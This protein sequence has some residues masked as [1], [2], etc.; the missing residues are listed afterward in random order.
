MDKDYEDLQ[1]DTAAGASFV[2]PDQKTNS[3]TP[4]SQTNNPAA[5]LIRQ[6]VASLYEKE[7][8]AGNEALDILELGPGLKKT[9]HQQFIEQLVGSGQPMVEIQTQWHNYYA[10]LPDAEKHAVWQE[11]YE[12]HAQV[13]GYARSAPMLAPETEATAASFGQTQTVVP[14][15]TNK[16][17]PPKTLSDLRHRLMPV[18]REGR[19]LKRQQHTKSLLF[20]LGMGF[21]AVFILLFGFFNERF[22]APL[23]TPSK[24]ISSTPI[25]NSSIIAVGPA[26]KVIIPKINVEVPVVYDINSVDEKIIQK[27]LESGVAH[28]ASTS[29]PGQD[30]NVVIFGHSSSN[31]FNR[32]RY[33]FAFML[34]SKMDKGDVFF[35]HKDGKRYS[36]EIYKKT[37]VKPTDFSVINQADNQATA[38]LIT[39]DPPGTS[40]NR[41]VVVGRQISP[42][43]SSNV[44]AQP[45]TLQ[46]PEAKILP[47]NAPSL[48]SRLFSWLSR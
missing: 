40:T 45:A 21:L 28:Y 19:Q 32:G 12:A 30:G 35:L 11:F 29:L 36:Y 8:P 34:L 14:P 43:P 27:A 15:S 46:L 26:S 44:A 22:I 1:P 6:K 3:A 42:D 4:G 24:A 37:V 48:W 16:I 17:S 5:D 18:A 39:C 47:S 38:T 2:V 23:I 31:I 41:L 20:G 25:I 13:S 9:R 33:K 7:P 10:G